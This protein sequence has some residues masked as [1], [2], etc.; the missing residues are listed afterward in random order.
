MANLY[1]EGFS[2][3]KKRKTTF[4]GGENVAG[5]V[6]YNWDGGNRPDGTALTFYVSKDKIGYNVTVSV[7]GYP[8][9]NY[10]IPKNPTTKKE[11]E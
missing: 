7:E 4:T 9:I 5:A 6:F 1:F 8:P 10:I 3:R 11:G 2:D